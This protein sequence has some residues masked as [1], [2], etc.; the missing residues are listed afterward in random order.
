MNG[1]TG[2]QSTQTKR[3]QSPTQLHFTQP[4][5]HKQ[6][7]IVPTRVI[8][9]VVTSTNAVL[10]HV[11]I[12]HTCVYSTCT[13]FTTVVKNNDIMWCQYTTGILNYN[14]VSG[15]YQ[16]TTQDMSCRKWGHAQP[17]YLLTKC[18]KLSPLTITNIKSLWCQTGTY[19]LNW[20]K[21]WF[22]FF[23]SSH[24]LNTGFY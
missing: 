20:I 24:N 11:S 16:H 4:S 9:A 22:Y 17:R 7:W 3:A 1:G 15:V 18:Y 6:Q 23:D 8:F 19:G 5:L 13:P 21:I 12:L 14:I 2:W 10:L